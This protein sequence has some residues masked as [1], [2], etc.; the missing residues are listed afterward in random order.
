M[1]EDNENCDSFM[2]YFEMIPIRFRSIES[3]LFY[4]EYRKRAMFQGEWRHKLGDKL[5]ISTCFL[6]GGW[7]QPIW[8][9]S[10]ALAIELGEMHTKIV[11]AEQ[12]LPKIQW[13]QNWAIKEFSHGKNDT[14]RRC[15][16]IADK[17]TEELLK[18]GEEDQVV[19]EPMI[20]KG[21][22]A[23]INKD[24]SVEMIPATKEDIIKMLNRG[25]IKEE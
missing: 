2:D 25:Y 15:E 5:I 23:K 24:G 7:Q 21:S 16:K 4:E 3:A 9:T 8:K 13:I 10:E 19:K 18:F 14:I 12:G 1:E 20:A 22:I 11:V 17:K 6:E